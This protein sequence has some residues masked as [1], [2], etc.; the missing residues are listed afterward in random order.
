M[1]SVQ[2]FVLTYFASHGIAT[3]ETPYK[4]SRKFGSGTLFPFCDISFC[5]GS[6]NS[7]TATWEPQHS[8]VGHFGAVVD[9]SWSSDSKTLFSVSTDQTARIQTQSPE[10]Q[11]FEIARPQVSPT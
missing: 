5:S 8:F 7:V 4:L 10:G 11:W 6:Q 1:P 3:P 2:K 9:I